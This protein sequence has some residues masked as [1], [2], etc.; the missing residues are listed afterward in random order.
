MLKLSLSMKTKIGNNWLLSEFLLT[1]SSIA[2]C[3]ITNFVPKVWCNVSWWEI[4]PRGVLRYTLLKNLDLL[5][6][7][8]QE[9]L[10]GT[11]TCWHRFKRS[12]WDSFLQHSKGSQNLYVYLR[13]VK[14]S[15]YK[16]QSSPHWWSTCKFFEF[17]WQKPIVDKICQPYESD[18]KVH[19][20][21]TLE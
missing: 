9:L 21:F 18:A 6:S 10:K 14:I 19:T 7:F 8:D 1:L 16:R 3:T 4:L 11:D 12:A 20:S 13:Y 2:V 15:I 5:H 17:L